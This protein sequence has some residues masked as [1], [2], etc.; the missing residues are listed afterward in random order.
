MIKFFRAY[1]AQ[2]H[3]KR[4]NQLCMGFVNVPHD[5]GMP[6]VQKKKKKK[7]KNVIWMIS[8]NNYY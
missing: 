4:K 8:N 5:P 2:F 7:K 3:R 6:D 1:C